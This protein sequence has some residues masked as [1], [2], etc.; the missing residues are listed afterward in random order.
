M[1]KCF[2][3]PFMKSVT[4]AAVSKCRECERS[5]DVSDLTSSLE[6]CLHEYK[7]CFFVFNVRTLF[8][9]CQ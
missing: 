2:F 7:S 5:G 8:L 6:N 3:N 9:V 1:I 4:E